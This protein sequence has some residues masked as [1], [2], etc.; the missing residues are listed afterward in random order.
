L[1]DLQTAATICTLLWG[2]IRNPI[3]PVPVATDENADQLLR[4]FQ[5]DVLF[6]VSQSEKID[7]FMARYPYLQSSR[8]SARD[9]FYEDWHTKKS[10]IAFLDSLNA[11][12]KYWQQE[13]KNAPPEHQSACRLV[14]WE[15]TDTLR[16][17]FALSYGMYPTHLNLKDDFHSGFLL[18]LRAQELRIPNNGVVHPELVQCI[19]PLS[20]T[21]IDLRGSGG[22]YHTSEGVY[23]GD[24]TSFADLTTF[25]N[26]RAAGSKYVFAP[27][28]ALPRLEPS[29]KLHLQHLDEQQDRHPHIPDHITMSF[30]KHFIDHRDE[31]RALIEQFP[32]RKQKA[33]S[34]RSLP[35]G[36]GIDVKPSTFYFSFDQVPALVEQDAGR[37]SVTITLP[38][39]KFLVESERHIDDQCLAISLNPLGD[40]GYPDHTLNPPFRTELNEFY[41]R[42]ISFDPWVIRSEEEGIGVLTSIRENAI[43]IRPIKNAAI[44][45]A[46]LALA[47]IKINPSAG[48]RLADRLC[49][50]L[51]GL[52]GVRVFKIRGVRK[53]VTSLRS[54]DATSRGNA[55]LTIF[56]EGQFKDHDGLYIEPRETGKLTADATFDFL[57]KNEFFRAGLELIC[58]HC[59][60]KS[61]LSLRQIDDTWICEFCG[62][63]NTTSLHIRNRGDW[64]FRKS[65]LLAKDNNQEGAIPVLLSLLVF[66]RVFHHNEDLQL[67]SV[68]VVE[69]AVPC[70]IDF[71]VI[72][73]QRGNL[74]WALGEAKSEG[75][76]ISNADNMKS[77]AQEL[78]EI[79]IT[80]YLVFSKTA[81]SFTADELTLFK[82]LHKEGHSLILLTN[83]EIEPYHAYGDNEE[84]D[85]TLPHKYAHSFSQMAA[86]SAWR[87]LR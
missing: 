65:G 70:E 54:Q 23:F 26:L 15:E 60:L 57:L 7:K 86:N 29:L 58:D 16:E 10:V 78:Q 31:M 55:T 24:A 67:T 79:G 32:T 25:W 45:E 82:A 30:D 22:S 12:E 69:G 43:S 85:K 87:Y 81:E 62:H 36:H 35:F 5:V 76:I 73:E 84:D 8:M 80:P 72:H 51:N 20:L 49:E 34:F 42:Q 61:W 74:E 18:G 68:K 2:G 44:V 1:A 4:L 56:N 37:Y 38:Q 14:H 50:K 77:V 41:S 75:G 83:M 64:R 40:F 33:V 19:T 52:E 53:L 17:L 71:M 63:A 47:K 28:A 21:S 39:K 9:L 13:F 3:I 46:I 66:K 11:V 6:P 27:I 48:G 59:G